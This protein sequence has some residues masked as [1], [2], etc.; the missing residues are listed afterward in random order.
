MKDDK[1]ENKHEAR[2]LTHAQR[3]KKTV[4]SREQAAQQ[5]TVAKSEHILHT[6]PTDASNMP[7]TDAIK[8]QLIQSHFFLRLLKSLLIIHKKKVKHVMA[9]SFTLQVN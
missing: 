1:A 8:H 2:V 5:C 6:A 9:S 3:W 7:S 4:G